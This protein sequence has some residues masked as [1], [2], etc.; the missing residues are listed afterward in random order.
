LL[1]QNVYVFFKHFAQC[2][3]EATEFGKITQNKGHCAVQGHS[4]K[5]TNFGTNR[6][7]IYD[8]LLV[9][10]TNIALFPRCSLRQ[11]ENRYIWLP[12]LRLPPATDGFPCGDLRKSFRGCQRMAKVTKWRRNTAENFNRLS[13]A[14]ERYRRQTE[15]P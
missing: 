8:F 3:P 11:V 7:L 2:A 10:N 5:V 1:S 12:L 14:H 13:M 6:K 15:R 9:I 4:I